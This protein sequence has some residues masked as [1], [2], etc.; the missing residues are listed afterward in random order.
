MLWWRRLFVSFGG[1]ISRATFWWSLIGLGLAFVV[2]LVALERAFGRN[3]SLIVYPMLFWAVAAIATK[4]LHDRAK[5]PAWFL[6]LLIPIV[7]P[8]WVFVELACLRG[9]RGENQYGPDPRERAG[10]YLTVK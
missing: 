10:D 5:A 8:L 2:V 3:S 6:L 9:T 7:G 4:R 1:R